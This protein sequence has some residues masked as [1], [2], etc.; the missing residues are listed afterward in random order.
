MIFSEKKK[1]VYQQLISDVEILLT[2]NGVSPI[3]YFRSQKV[4]NYLAYYPFGN[5]LCKLA[6]AKSSLQTNEG[7]RQFGIFIQRLKGSRNHRQN[8][9]LDSPSDFRDFNSPCIGWKQN[10]R[11]EEEVKEYNKK[12]SQYERER[13]ERKERREKLLGSSEG[14]TYLYV[15]QEYESIICLECKGKGMIISDKE[16]TS[17]SYCGGSGDT[18]Y[19]PNIV[20]PQ[21]RVAREVN[22]QLDS[23]REPN[24]SSFPCKR[25]SVYVRVA[26]GGQIFIVDKGES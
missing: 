13:G 17:C 6:L 14:R 4:L 8:L 5:I 21:I 15:K 11:F 19:T 12:S 22:A 10:S 2:K 25:K 24:F 20:P 7:E 18:G 23:L 3:H 1:K 16:S 26:Y 9:L